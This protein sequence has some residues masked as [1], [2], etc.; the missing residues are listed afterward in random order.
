MRKFYQAVAVEPREGG[1][2]VLLDGKPMR[3]PARRLLVAPTAA[4]AEGIAAEWRGQEKRLRPN[5]MPLTQL[6]NTALDRMTEA[7]IR[8]TVV[9]EIAGYAATDLVCYR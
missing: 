5:T 9:A 3:T 1:F 2:A 7:K 8:E 6:L 4:L